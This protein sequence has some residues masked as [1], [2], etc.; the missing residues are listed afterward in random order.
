MF[1]FPSVIEA[2][3]KHRPVICMIKD[4]PTLQYCHKNICIRLGDLYRRVKKSP[5]KVPIKADGDV[6]LPS[7][8]PVKIVFV[9][10][11]HNQG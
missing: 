5:G 2:L 10:N 7:G 11:R 3:H 1:A 8:L 6:T 4:L 9:R